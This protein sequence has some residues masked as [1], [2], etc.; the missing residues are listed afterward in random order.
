LV[1]LIYHCAQNS[2]RQDSWYVRF[3][4]G[5]LDDRNI[6]FHVALNRA[7]VHPLSQVPKYV[8]LLTWY[9]RDAQSEIL[10]PM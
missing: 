1:N 10:C 5:P 7:H 6:R 8:Y 9:E 3:T 4:G 2:N